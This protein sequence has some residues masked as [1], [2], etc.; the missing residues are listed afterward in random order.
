MLTAFLRASTRD[1][2][3]V[4]DLFQ[5]TMLV[6]WRRLDDYDRERPFGAWLRGIASKL[7]LSHFRQKAQR[8]D[9]AVEEE[10][11]EWFGQQLDRVQSFSGDT[12]DEKLEALRRCVSGLPDHYREV[13]HLRYEKEISLS[14]LPSLLDLRFEALKKRIGRAKQMLYECIQRKLSLGE[15]P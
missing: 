15:V 7:I 2:A 14:D 11:L 1:P 4:D 10:T 9:I 6:A 13:I 8:R 5:E 12:W 3:V